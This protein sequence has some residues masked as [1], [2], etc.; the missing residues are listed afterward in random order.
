MS[1]AARIAWVA[2]LV[3]LNLSVTF[4]H[5]WPTLSVRPTADLSLELAIITI[6]L[7]WWQRRGQV[8]SRL[9][10]RTLAIGWVLLIVGRYVGVT[11][12]G[13]YGRDVNLYWDVRH[14][15]SIGAMFTA[16]ATNWAVAAGVVVVAAAPV[17]LYAASRWCLGRLACGTADPPARRWLGAA[18]G[19][20]VVLWGVEQ[21]TGWRPADWLRFSDPVAP[22]YAREAYEV[23]YEASGAGLA[24]LGPPPVIRSDLA[25]VAGADVFV[26]FME[27]Y[28][29]V[30]WESST[31][32]EALA[33]SRTRLADDIRATGR[34]VMSTLV[35]SPTFGGESWLAHL[36]L[37]S[38][39][40][41]RD[42]RTNTR[43]LAQERDT[44]VTLFQR[45]GYHAVALVPGMLVAWPEGAF[46]RYDDV[47]DYD[48]LGYR[49]PPFGWWS[50]TDQYAL[51]ALDRDEIA[52]RR[53][54]PRFVFFSTISTHAPFTP[55]PPYQADWGRVLTPQPYDA[56]ALDAAWAETP[57]WMNLGPSYVQALRYAYATIGGYL[58]LRADRDLVL[59]L[60]GDH[61]PPA[62]VSGASASWD[63]PVHVITS[64]EALIDRL[65]SHRFRPGLAPGVAAATTMH[66]LL[67]VLLDAFGDAHR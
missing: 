5:V 14:M 15:P 47:Y 6:G 60:V 2:A 20:V 65:V 61:Q 50:V 49:G 34:H 41:V 28:G 57:D 23:A 3:L 46:Y 67:P 24:A 38:G 54:A 32:A 55:A 29:A 66:G 30:S 40:E 43:L 52:P 22:T 53:R 56:D 64:R 31:L 7:L 13:L 62:L 11:T 27:S 39:T 10:L 8:A 33:P 51:A 35:E 19:L 59:I 58:R 1:R 18:A 17:L 63:V 37:L 45:G 21:T 36:S 4:E 16:V 26:I 12:E 44:L 9:L 25:R 48:R 42:N